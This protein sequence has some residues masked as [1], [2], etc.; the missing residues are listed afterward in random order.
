[1]TNRTGIALAVGAL[2]LIFIIAGANKNAPVQ[3]PPSKAQLDAIAA[4]RPPAPKA[5]DPAS[6]LQ[7]RKAYAAQLDE[8][9]LS[10]GIES[11][12]TTEG[13][14]ARTLLIRDVL[15]GRVR[16]KALGENLRWD[17][18]ERLG[19]KKVVYTSAAGLCC[20]AGEIQF[21]WD[22]DKASK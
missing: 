4:Y 1:M 17:L 18:L 20:D 2:A 8:N 7:S 6:L 10:A 16:A 3:E 12:T 19:F 22:V 15:A 13:P 5:P 14:E 21:K 9:L 11:T